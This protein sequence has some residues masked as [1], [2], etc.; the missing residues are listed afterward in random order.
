MLLVDVVSVDEWNLLKEYFLLWRLTLAKMFS[1]LFVFKMCVF[2]FHAQ[3]KLSLFLEKNADTPNWVDDFL[4]EKT[5][6]ENKSWLSSRISSKKLHQQRH[7][8]EIVKDL[9]CETKNLGIIFF[10]FFM[11]SYFSRISFFHF[12]CFPFCILFIFFHFSF[13]SFLHVFHFSHFFLCFFVFLFLCFFSS[14]FFFLQYQSLTID[15]SCRCFMEMWCPDDIGRDS[16][17]WVAPP[18]WERA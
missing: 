4:L 14:S 6:S 16:W 15:V 8:L 17:D 10:A 9:A 18:T 7:P 5:H 1:L 3:R 13:F 11:F 2:C 12:S